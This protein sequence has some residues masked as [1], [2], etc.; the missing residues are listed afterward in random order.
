MKNPSVP[1]FVSQRPPQA[2]RCFQGPLIESVI[3]DTK[4]RIRDPE[5]AWMFENCFPNTLDT[6]VQCGSLNGRPD[7][8]VIT[9]DIPAMWLRDSTAQ[10]WPYIRFANQDP[11]L[12]ELL[13]GVIN[14]QAACVRLDPYAN[15]FNRG[16][17]GSEWA[18]DLTDMRPELHER[19]WEIDSLCHVVRLAY[20]YWCATGDVGFVDASW[21]E[22]AR[23]IL[24]TFR[25]QQRFDGHGPY[26]F[27]RMTELASD[28]LPMGGVGYPVKP[29]GLIYSAFRPSDD[30]CLLHFLIP[31][32]FF[33]VTALRQMAY[34]LDAASLD[35]E[36]ARQA[37]ALAAQVEAALALHASVPHARLGTIWAYEADGYGNHLLMDDASIPS[38]LSL[39]YLGCCAG[40]DERYLATRA[41]ALSQDNAF[42]F[43]GTCGEGIGSPHCGL[44][45]AWPMG[46][47]M[48]AL[49]SVD[50]AE[51]ATCLA[52]LKRTHAGTGFMHESFDVNDS[53]RF[54]RS[55]FAWANT[56]FGELIVT[57][58]EK[59]PDLLSEKFE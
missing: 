32:N 57:L 38:L 40:D 18:K 48:Q 11:A 45:L 1:A 14:R 8:F 3:A 21:L 5:L 42:Y 50:P 20:G 31:S 41:Y 9:G 19:K 58:A 12:R 2:D 4:A 43:K 35:A 53:A 29:C 56:L 44:N 15:A 33:A 13:L 39:P 25:Q 10:V 22:T 59:A 51:I 7:T 23:A 54:T 55:W 37:R 36:T 16:P 52:Q 26:R 27:Q 6:T 34:L 47:I 24:T 17:S 28:T 30:A 49:T 46:I